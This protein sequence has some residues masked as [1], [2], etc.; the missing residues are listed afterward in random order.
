MAKGRKK[1]VNPRS[2]EFRIRLTPDEQELLRRNARIHGKSMSDYIR[3]LI[4]YDDYASLM[5]DDK[6]IPYPNTSQQLLEFAHG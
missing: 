1:S 4:K 5:S 6:R 3:W 2:K